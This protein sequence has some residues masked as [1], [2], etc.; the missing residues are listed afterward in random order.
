MGFYSKKL[1]WY[2][3]VRGKEQIQQISAAIVP[4][5]VLSIL[6]VK[7]TLQYAIYLTV[8]NVTRLVF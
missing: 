4:G 2:L 8:L 5:K 3:F 7:V 6:L 1:G